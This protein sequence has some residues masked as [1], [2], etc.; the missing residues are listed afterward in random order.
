MDYRTEIRNFIK[1]N[2]VIEDEDHVFNDD[3]NYF[4]MRFVN[5]LFAMRLVQFIEEKIGFEIP[6]EYIEL[7]NFCTVNKVI[8]LI[9]HLT[10]QV[11]VVEQS[12]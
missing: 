12:A 5:S 4:E 3:D 2:F 9:S 10:R 11:V 6:N 7:K 8:D 1:T